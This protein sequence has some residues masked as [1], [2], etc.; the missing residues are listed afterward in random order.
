[1]KIIVLIAVLFL[2]GCGH[3]TVTKKG[4]DWTASSTT[5]FKKLE[6]VEVDVKDQ[7]KVNLGTS[8]VSPISNEVIACLIAPQLCR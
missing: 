8:S 2:A 4:A 7:V 6:G 5:L 1:M 3:V